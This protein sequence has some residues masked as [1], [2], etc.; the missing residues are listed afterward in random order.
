MHDTL[1]TGESPLNLIILEPM[2]KKLLL[3]IQKSANSS[4]M[5]QPLSMIVAY[6]NKDLKCRGVQ[7]VLLTS[8]G[9]VPSLPVPSG[10]LALLMMKK[11]TTNIVPCSKLDKDVDSGERVMKWP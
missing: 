6:V 10:A 11:T 1:K 7:K 9:W 4:K 2:T 8:K 5:L 3:Q